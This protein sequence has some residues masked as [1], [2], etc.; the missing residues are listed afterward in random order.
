M[1]F[2]QGQA[3]RILFIPIFYCALSTAWVFFSDSVIWHYTEQLPTEFIKHASLIKGVTFVFLTSILLAFLLNKY[4]YVLFKSNTNIRRV[5]RKINHI[6]ATYKHSINE[7]DAIFNNSLIGIVFIDSAMIIRRVNNHFCKILNEP[8][9][10]YIGSSVTSKPRADN[11]VF[12]QINTAIDT[13][14]KNEGPAEIEF[15]TKFP[16]GG[17][18]WLQLSITKIKSVGSMNGYVLLV[19]DTTLRKNHEDKIVYLSYYDFLTEL[20]NRRL[21]YEKLTHM[22]KEA[23]RYGDGFGVLYMDI[24]NFKSYNDSHGHEFGDAVLKSFAN[25]IRTTLRDSDVVARLGGDE[26]AAIISRVGKRSSFDKIIRKLHL[27]LSEIVEIDGIDVSLT[28]SIGLGIFPL[29]GNDADA[30]LN[31]ADR[32]MYVEKQHCRKPNSDSLLPN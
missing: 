7:L 11:A 29:D 10:C 22:C 30:I 4:A 5:L 2:R 8:R 31:V 17:H 27:G 24:N 21:F 1:R 13:C 32:A 3:K 20:P 28:A 18:Q 19:R 14:K 15:K 6:S 25:T 26:F 16:D 12:V 9:E 23:S